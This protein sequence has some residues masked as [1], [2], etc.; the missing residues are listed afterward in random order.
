MSAVLGAPELDTRTG[1]S[2]LLKERILLI[3][4]YKNEIHSLIHIS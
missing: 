4:Y 1:E 2:Q 3:L